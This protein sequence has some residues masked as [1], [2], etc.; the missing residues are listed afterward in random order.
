[1]SRENISCNVIAA[2]YHDHIFVNEADGEK[3]LEVLKRLSKQD[4]T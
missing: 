2:D 4:L 3:A 1:M